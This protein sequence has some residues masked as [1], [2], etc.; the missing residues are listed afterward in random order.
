MTGQSYAGEFSDRF[1]RLID[2]KTDQDKKRLAS[3]TLTGPDGKPLTADAL[4]AQEYLE[5]QINAVFDNL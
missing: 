1:G 3:I 5:A 4:P 2:T